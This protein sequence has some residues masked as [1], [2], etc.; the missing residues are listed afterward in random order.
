M[1]G[2]SLPWKSEKDGAQYSDAIVFLL[3]PYY[4]G[5]CWRY[6]HAPPLWLTGLCPF[7]YFTHSTADSA[8]KEERKKTER[9]RRER[10]HCRRPLRL[11]MVKVAAGKTELLAKV[12]ETREN[13]SFLFFFLFFIRQELIMLM[14]ACFL[15]R[16]Q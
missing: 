4:T 10:P 11:V 8:R 9:D 15:S 13:L 6:R 7:F 14:M 5:G 2:L 1:C 16:L 3:F 12:E